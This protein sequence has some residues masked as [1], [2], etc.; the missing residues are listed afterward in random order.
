LGVRRYAEAASL[1][2]D[3]ALSVLSQL[4]FALVGGA[5]WLVHGQSIAFAAQIAVGIG[6]MI[7]AAGLFVVVQN[8]GTFEKVTALANR[9]ASGR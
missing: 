3:M 1:L 9:F 4:A 7:V 5:L 8:A 6:V 2:I